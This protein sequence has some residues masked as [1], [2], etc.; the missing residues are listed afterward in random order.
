MSHSIRRVQVFVYR[1][2]IAIP[3]MTSF[4][5]MHDRPAVIVRVEDA[6]GCHGWGEVWCNYPT[7][8]AEHR[9]RLVE[10]V[11]A[12]LLIDYAFDQPQEVFDYL[13]RKTHVLAIQTAEVGPIAQAIAGV[14]IALWDLVARRANKPL[15]QM[16][17]GDVRQ[18][19]AYA[20]GIN[21]AGA[22]ET[23]GRARE[24]GYWAFKVKIG[25]GHEADLN[26]LASACGQLSDGE[27]IMTDANQA[28]DW[29]KAQGFLRQAHHLPLAWLE[30]PIAADRP[31]DEWRT[32]AATSKIPIAAGENIRGA[33][34][35]D[36]WIA[37]AA[38][39]V[40]QPDICKWGGISGNLPII[41]AI[42]KA[43]RR[44]CPHF[45]GGGIGLMASAHLLAAVGGDG[46]LEVDFNA[47]PLREGLADPFPTI[48]DGHMHLKSSIGLGVEPHD[49]AVSSYLVHD[50]EI[51]A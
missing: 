28:W 3:V 50:V 6:E 46:M 38:I 30:E 34:N 15:A 25:F 47:N 20:S 35:F 43:G 45:L 13:T 5:T 10:T 17:G 1:A 22:D 29:E 9:A 14:D 21:P 51:S 11:I 23:I 48:A 8:G 33:A 2:P 31:L 12:P 32:L 37:S 24:E 41:H 42:L 16:M 40:I 36:T 26:T 18:I 27:A 19:P 7:C 44:Y 39:G 49:D 4:G